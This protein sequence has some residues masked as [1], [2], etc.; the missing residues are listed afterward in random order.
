MRLPTPRCFHTPVFLANSAQPSHRVIWCITTSL[1][2]TELNQCLFKK[3]NS[4][5]NVWLPY[6]NALDLFFSSFVHLDLMENNDVCSPRLKNCRCNK[7]WVPTE[8]SNP[9]RATT[10][11]FLCNQT[12]LVLVSSLVLQEGWI[13]KDVNRHGI[14]TLCRVQLCIAV[15]TILCTHKITTIQPCWKSSLLVWP[16][17]GMIKIFGLNSSGYH[18]SFLPNLTLL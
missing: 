14:P 6:R 3:K 16:I 1:K 4:L 15:L 7:K 17:T 5:W 10:K 2:S 11:R 12:V 9:S 18:L 13:K 8:T